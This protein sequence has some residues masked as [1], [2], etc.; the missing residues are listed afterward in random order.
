MRDG[1][2]L[3]REG[4][5]S[6]LAATLDGV[7]TGHGRLVVIEGEA[8][9]GK[10]AL[11]AVAAGLARERGARVVSARGG[12]LEQEIA[13]GVVR[14]LFEPVVL[15]R[16][17]AEA[18][19]E[20]PARA[21]APV[22][23]LE[24]PASEIAFPVDVAPGLEHALF[25]LAVALATA[26]PLVVA[27]D[28]AHW[29]DEASLRWLVYLGRRVERFPIALLVARRS[30]EPS[31]AETLLGEL[32]RTATVLTPAP[33]TAAG[34]AVLARDML[35]AADATLVETCR[36]LTGGNPFF[37]GEMFGELAADGREPTPE[38]VRSQRPD[39]VVADVTRR[40]TRLSPEAVELARATALLDGHA[41]L[42]HAVGLAGL[43][44]AAGERAADELTYARLLAP[45]RPLRFAHPILRAA[46][47]AD[48][49]PARRAAAHRL[50]G[51]LLDGE[52][53]DRAAAHLTA[54]EPAGD[55]W[56]AQRLRAAGERATARGAPETAVRLLERARR[57]PCDELALRVA[58]GRAYRLKGRLA[59]AAEALG[60]ALRALPA[61]AERDGL[62]SELATVLAL[63]ARGH[64]A[65]DVL[66][67]EIEAL[68]P[69]ARERRLLLASQLGLAMLLDELVVEASERIEREA[70]DLTGVTDPE[71]LLLGSLALIR[72]RTGTRPARDA[73]EVAG[74]AL[75][76]GGLETAVG[77]ET[78][79][80]P[81]VAIALLAAG[82]DVAA[83]RWLERR[84]AEAKAAGAELALGITELG[85][86]RVHRFR[87]E[88]R[89]ARAVLT[90]AL[91]RAMAGSLY[92]R[93]L[94]GGDLVAT[95]VESGALDEAERTLGD[96]G[97]DAG[98]LPAFGASTTLLRAR[99][100][101]RSAQRRHADAL[102]DADELLS[103]LARRGHGAPGP[104][105]DVA[106]VSLAAG[107][108]ERARR[109]A[110]EE[111]ERA[112]RWD[113]PA[114][115]G[116]AQLQLGRV[117]GRDALLEQAVRNLAGSPCRLELAR[118]QLACG[119]AW[120]RGNRRADARE[121]LR[122]ALDLA[123]RC[124]AAALAEAARVELRACGARPRRSLLSGPDSLTASE[125]RVA[126][127]AAQGLS[128]PEIARA[129]VVSRSTVESHLRAAFRKL[130]VRSRRHLARAL[131]ESSP[132]VNDASAVGDRGQ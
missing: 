48:L 27:V 5:C 115:I 35:G 11:M 129:L 61:G 73:A 88:L 28:D 30:G 123:E 29:A 53:P 71:R 105:G 52:S 127:L 68:P 106:L 83:G 81:F 46:V 124:G 55:A 110:E 86:A 26:S 99:M 24:A 45:G 57:E 104:L 54:C 132:R 58:L 38:R 109:Q 49:P 60:S 92:G 39:K 96:L 12:L 64:E 40:L 56:V 93:V 16:E 107:D 77:P 89:P 62:A 19:F 2:L 117:I 121:R 75:R 8:G 118:A 41:E 90:S 43:P 101:L 6:A 13:W 100:L 15:G 76:G 17:P 111:L 85:L 119:A 97:L 114:A 25:R 72:A 65:V 91:E 44:L 50:A 20:G 21:A 116:L 103:R 37:L 18:L 130:D 63:D 22:F 14:Q 36:E 87:G 80:S 79:L 32:V 112:R 7:S 69:E 98:P 82:R 47:E 102:A 126:E 125:R 67:R 1:R 66:E 108:A 34:T 94:I 122:Q 95:L 128:N 120:R 74:R 31:P 10:S 84:A 78:F 9:L 3:E 4:E 42:R 51:A 70:Q 23:G 113:T 33:L 59:D 131:G